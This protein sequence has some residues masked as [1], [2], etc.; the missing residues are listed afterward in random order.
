MQDENIVS[1]TYMRAQHPHRFRELLIECARK[2]ERTLCSM[3]ILSRVLFD[4]RAQLLDR[5]VRDVPIWHHDS[6]LESG[7]RRTVHSQASL[8]AAPVARA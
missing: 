8:N 3:E 4:V 5:Y 2:M 1:D 6:D 7:T